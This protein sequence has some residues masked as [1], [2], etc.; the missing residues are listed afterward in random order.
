MAV[1]VSS[2]FRKSLGCRKWGCNKWGF[3]GCLTALPGNR[4]KSAFFA[5]FLPFRTFPEGSKSTRKIQKM[6][7][8]GSFP[9]ISSDLL[10]PPSL[11]PPFAAPQVETDKRNIR[12]NFVLQRCSPQKTREG[13]GCFRG[14]F[15]GSQGKLRESTK[16]IAGNFFPNH[17]MLQ[18]LGFGAL[19]KAN[20]PGTLGRHCREL[21]PH[22][23]C[24][25]F[26]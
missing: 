11:K 5:P 10:E 20:L 25:V 3:K 4:P 24:G 1:V 22:P 17:E 14:L 2:A 19:G 12:A 7:E 13:C 8:K 15:G 6:Q 21:C 18:I 9:Q 16:K 23:P 26:F